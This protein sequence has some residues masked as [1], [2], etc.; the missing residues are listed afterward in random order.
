MNFKNINHKLGYLDSTFKMF[1]LSDNINWQL[2][3]CHIYFFV[4]KISYYCSEI[5]IIVHNLKLRHASFT[6]VHY[7]LL[8]ILSFKKNRILKMDYFA[9]V[10]IQ[11][12]LS[13]LTPPLGLI[14][15]KNINISKCWFRKMFYTIT[16]LKI[17]FTD[18][19]WLLFLNHKCIKVRLLLNMC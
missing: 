7:L 12:N 14:Q 15:K 11:W 3:W 2:N 5:T 17:Y 8:L 1:V 18:S 16:Y 13:N 10:N 9:N 6:F 19:L 4:Y